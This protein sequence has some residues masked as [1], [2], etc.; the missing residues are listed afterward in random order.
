MLYGL[1]RERSGFVSSAPSAGRKFERVERP[2][3]GALLFWTKSAA[4]RFKAQHRAALGGG[5]AVAHA[6]RLHAFWLG[7]TE[8]FEGLSTGITYDDDPESPRSRA[9]DRGRNVGE[10]FARFRRA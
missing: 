6:S 7:L 5:W 2:S 8:G 10:W 1:Y 9:Y 4:E 3:D